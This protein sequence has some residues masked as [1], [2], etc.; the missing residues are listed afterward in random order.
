MKRLFILVL[1]LLAIPVMADLIVNFTVVPLVLA[2]V[3]EL[4][5]VSAGSDLKAVLTYEMKTDSGAVYK[6]GAHSFILSP[7]QRT[8]VLNFINGDAIPA[9]NV[10]EGL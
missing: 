1:V 5:I 3:V 10:A 6:R 7:A 8:A 9:A 2:D 4:S